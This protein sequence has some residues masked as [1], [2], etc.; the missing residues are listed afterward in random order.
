MF[1]ELNF[2]NSLCGRLE[3]ELT[4]PV[5]KIGKLDNERAITEARIKS[6]KLIPEIFLPETKTFRPLTQQE[7]R[8]VAFAFPQISLRAESG[9]VVAHDAPNGEFFSVQDLLN[10]VEETERA[11][12]ENSEWFCGIDIHHIFFEGIYPADDG[13]W[14]IHWGS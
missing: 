2:F 13:S 10:A 5:E 8:R 3:I 6:L 14:D 9:G 1:S 7:L 12:R 11:T 4:A